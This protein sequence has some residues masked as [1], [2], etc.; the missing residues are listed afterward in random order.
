[1]PAIEEAVFSVK[2]NDWLFEQS[3]GAD[4]G[5]LPV[6]VWA[7]SH[8]WGDMGCPCSLCPLSLCHGPLSLAFYPEFF[9]SA[10]QTA[11]WPFQRYIKKC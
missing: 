6:L 8:S 9:S 3:R 2:L 7:C 4:S 11:I 10:S 1:M 5:P